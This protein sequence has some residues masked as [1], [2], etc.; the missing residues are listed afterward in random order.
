[1]A[2]ADAKLHITGRDVE[3][4]TLPLVWDGEH[5]LW[6]LLDHAAITPDQMQV[7]EA[8]KAAGKP[9][10]PLELYPRIGKNHDATRQLLCRMVR[11]GLVVRSRGKYLP[12]S[13][14]ESHDDANH[15]GGLPSDDGD[16]VTE[17][18]TAC[19][20]VTGGSGQTSIP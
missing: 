2:A 9:L 18:V 14:T 6:S 13:V 4:Q 15:F 16:G 3:E 7:L 11:D 8:L 20:P 10:T 5:C 12:L 19:H 1:V 17:V